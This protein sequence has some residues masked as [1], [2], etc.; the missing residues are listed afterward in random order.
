MSR[1]A[2][3]RNRT[4]ITTGTISSARTSEEQSSRQ[5]L[6]T[7]YEQVTV[8]KAGI[9]RLPGN[10]LRRLTFASWV[11]GISKL[12][13][14]VPSSLQ[15]MRLPV[16]FAYAYSDCGKQSSLWTPYHTIKYAGIFRCRSMP[17][18]QLPVFVWPRIFR[19]RQT[20][21]SMNSLSYY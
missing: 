6:T 9:F 8:V 4:W 3:W 2:N 1:L 17:L 16:L 10:L 21:F 14:L 12:P 20:E 15:F 18:M 7:H 5:Y 19:L 13:F 11:V